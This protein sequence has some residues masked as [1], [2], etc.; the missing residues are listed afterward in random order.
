MGSVKVGGNV[1]GS[2]IAAGDYNV[3]TVTFGGPDAAEREELL[4]AL[5]LIQAALGELK[6]ASAKSAQREATAAVDAAKKQEVDKDEIGG[7]LETALGAAKK[8]EEFA[9]I[10]SKLLPY[11]QTVAAWLG[12]HWTSLLAV[13]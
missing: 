11:I 2:A 1:S 10:S 5:Q 12:P 7:A 6:G 4:A 13:L 9:A 3:Q 8:A